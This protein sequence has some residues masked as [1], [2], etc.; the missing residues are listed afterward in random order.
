MK[1]YLIGFMGSGKSTIGRKLANHLHFDFVDLDRLIEIKAGM[2]I[3]EYFNAHGEE[4]F[5]EFERDVLRQSVF[6]ENTIIATGG[7]APCYFN[8]MAWMN[9]TGKTVYLSLE[10]K[11]L[12]NR[13]ENAK[14]QRPLIKGL[15]GEELVNFIKLKLGSRE[16]FYHEAQ[17]IV[18]GTDL[19]A[20]RLSGYLGLHS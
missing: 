2:S 11:A 1:I 14:V 5:R 13:L 16:P 3:A 17:F 18:S 12:A 9:E 19:T 10:P 8:N 7:G 20:E 15:S 4:K 6:P